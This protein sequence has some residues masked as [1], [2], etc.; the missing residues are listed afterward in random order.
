MAK[1]KIKTFEYK[2]IG[3]ESTMVSHNGVVTNVKPGETV[4]FTEQDIKK[5]SLSEFKSVDDKKTSYEK[6]EK[7]GE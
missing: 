6:I 3:K 7:T 1:E 2:H 5:Q 4:E